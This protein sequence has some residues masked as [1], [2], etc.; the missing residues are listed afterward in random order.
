M[1]RS[2]PRADAPARPGGLRL[3]A[4]VALGVFIAADDQ[5]S[6]VALLPTMVAD[7][8]VTADEFY[9][10]SWVVNGYL[11]GY[12]AALPVVGRLAD[13]YGHG[14]VYALSLCLFM[15]GSALVAVAP[16]METAVAARALQAVGGG[17]VVPVAMAIV[18]D[19]LPARRRALGL[20]AIAAASEA[21]A[22]LGPLWGGGLAE[23]AGWRSVF[24]VNLPMAAPLAFA[25][26]RLAGRE[27]RPGTVDWRGAA[28]LVAALSLLTLGLVDDP[29]ARRPPW[30]TAALL[31]AAVAAG[32]WFLRRAARGAEPL[33]RPALLGERGVRVA[34]AAS[35]LMGG[36]LI[37]ALIAV[38]LF[39]NLVLAESPLAGGLTLMR[40]TVAVPLGAV[41][42]GWWSGRWGVRAPLVAGNAAAAVGFAWLMTWDEGLSEFARTAPQLLAGFG[43]GLVIAPL[44]A[45]ALQHARE[46]E[47][48][49]L[50]SWLTLARMTGMLA[51]T[52][53]L[54]S[55]G[56]GRFYTR[57]GEVPFGS[58]EFAALVAEA[59]VSTFR[60]VFAGG[61]VVML[62]AAAVALAVGS[63]RA[64]DPADAW[65]TIT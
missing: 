3:L 52:A 28:L 42:G 6:I 19:H 15:L 34:L 9:R 17:G 54:T 12:L 8:G 37:T 61:L 59:Q 40:L 20:G 62:L 23:L 35:L 47:R 63:T 13:V 16:T 11:L 10:I 58:P 43:F 31:V 65:W 21:G 57:V 30:Q 56:L 1:S 25:A 4:V 29:L 48:A 7:L 38:P 33:I 50:A 5:T 60:E 44:G 26:W 41:A 32:G 64:A 39:A 14:R 24:W 2:S 53:L 36:G 22:L 27:R 46:A 45:A 18:V 55:R 51:G 49:A